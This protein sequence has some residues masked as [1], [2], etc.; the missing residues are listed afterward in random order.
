[1][2]F[3][4]N[5][6]PTIRDVAREAGV[7]YQ[8]VS[9]VINNHPKVAAITRER[10]QHIIDQM[11]Y[12]KNHA[13]EMLRTHRTHII[14]VIVVDGKFP[15]ELPLL[16]A[17]NFG[18]YYAVYAECTAETL[19][20]SLATAAARMIEGIF[21]YGPKLTISDED[22]V[23]IS[24]GLPI[25]RRDF[26][27]DSM[28]SWVG[29]D[30]VAAT[31]LAV[32]HLIEL[33]H[34]H[35]AEVTGSLV[36]LNVA[37]RHQIWEQ[38]LLEHGLTPGPSAMGDYT[39]S[40]IAIETGYEG[41]CEILKRGELFT[42]VMVANDHMA[43]GV[44]HALHQQGLRIP[45]DVSI[46]S[47]D[48]APHARFLNPPLTTIKFDFDRQNRLAFRCLFEMIHNRDSKPQ[49]HTLMPELIVRESTRRV[50]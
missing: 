22:L 49:Q 8:T 16:D 7:S 45:D 40:K 3:E 23:E 15:F 11:G 19:A 38:T 41:M 26:A 21:L 43:T 31:R 17:A 4:K 46:V 20:Q 12:Q 32:Q 29:F 10:V 33:G 24:C 37:L 42:A 30:Q 2:H 5:G 47:F 1:M 6:R 27:P 35:I 34:H 25:V 50:G 14:Q 48:N 39:T 13:A 28:M 9:R 44:I 18:D 36:T